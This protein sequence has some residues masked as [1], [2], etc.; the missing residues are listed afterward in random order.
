MP[1]LNVPPAFKRFLH[2]IHK[3]GVNVAFLQIHRPGSDEIQ[4]LGDDA[5]QSF[6]LGED[7]LG[8]FPAG[9]IGPSRRPSHLT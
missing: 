8:V 4:G 5:V 7:V 1:V 3:E 6:N 2:D 9:R